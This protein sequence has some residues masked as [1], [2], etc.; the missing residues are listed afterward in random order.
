MSKWKKIVA[1]V[2][3]TER[4]RNAARE[5]LRLAHQHKAAVHAFHV[6]ESIAVSD[7][8]QALQV[9]MVEIENE[10]RVDTQARL[11]E[12]L[13]AVLP[14]PYALADEGAEKAGG[15][16][17]RTRSVNLTAE[18][19]LGQPVDE[20]LK[21]VEQLGADLLVMARNSTSNPNRGAGTCASRCVRGA[22]ADVLLVRDDRAGPYKRVIACIDFSEHSL[23]A[24]EDAIDI[25][26]RDRAEIHLVHA[27]HPPWDIV[28]FGAIPA[29]ASSSL[30]NEYQGLLEQRLAKLAKSASKKAN[31]AKV[32]HQII[33]AATHTSAL[34]D[35][36][37]ESRADL[38]VVGSHGRTGLARFLIGSTAERIVRDAPCSVL[39]VKAR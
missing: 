31:G 27:F 36:L 4:S 35:Y 23:R 28:H 9:P 37:A 32:R 21:R 25:A 2:D 10:V 11:R 22:K 1:A 33:P 18:V 34:V 16:A 30:Q 8:Q 29:D 20:V 7:L 6:V 39:T 14:G 24:L 13:D 19:V 15:T 3:F 17:T 38:A 12:F 26:H 5:A